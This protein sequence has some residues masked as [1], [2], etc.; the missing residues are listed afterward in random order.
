MHWLNYMLIFLLHVTQYFGQRPYQ[1]TKIPRIG[2]VAWQN[3]SQK[4][5]IHYIYIPRR[6]VTL[7]K[8]VNHQ[9]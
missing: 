7:V 5:Q 4:R 6:W 1:E 9:T 8:H 3:Q 2:C